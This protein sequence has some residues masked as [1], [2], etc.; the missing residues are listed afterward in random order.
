MN[1]TLILLS[2]AFIFFSIFGCTGTGTKS[3][4]GVNEAV[5]NTTVATPQEQP[6][7][8][9][10]INLTT[11][12]SPSGVM[13][14]DTVFPK[15]EV[16]DFSNRTTADGRLIVYFFYSPYCSACK[17]T[18]PEVD[19]LEQKYQNVSWEEYDITTQNGSKAYLDYASQ[20]NLSA[21]ERYVPQVL[22]DGRVI[23]DRF[24]INSTLESVIQNFSAS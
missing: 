12:R 15:I 23:T 21:K 2:V 19:R 5:T 18:I 7:Q 16:Y 4:V 17:A 10:T 8:H 22:V 3:G 13:T 24:N 9:I 20:M 6:I 14:T 1:R 11:S